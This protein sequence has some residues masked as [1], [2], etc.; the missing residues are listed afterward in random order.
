[1]QFMQERLAWI[2]AQMPRAFDTLVPANLEV[3]RLPPAEEPGAPTAYGGAGR[4]TAAFRAKIWINLRT[5]DLHRKYTC[6]R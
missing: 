2:R 3:R 1:M 5:T 6:R 4:R